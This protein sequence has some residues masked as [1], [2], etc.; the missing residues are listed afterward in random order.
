MWRVRV[1]R[2]RCSSCAD[3]VFAERVKGLAGARARRSD[4]LA[5]AQTDI[6]LVL[7][8]EAGAHLSRRLAMQ[9]S[10]DTVLRLVRRR[11]IEPCP[12]PQVVGVDDWAWRR[13]HGYG[14]I[15]CDLERRRVIDLLP[16]RSAEPLRD[17]LDAHPSVRVVSRDR[18]GPYAEAA[19]T[20]AP[21]ATQV[22]DRC[23][24][25]RPPNGISV[26]S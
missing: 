15:V 11:G 26:P 9:V 8:G 20:G 2:F 3:R 16:G 12:P 24:G 5:A 7:G 22:A 23:W 4:R 14:T 18:S 19:R 1:R 21:A 17:W 10:G 25:E 6:G 13:G